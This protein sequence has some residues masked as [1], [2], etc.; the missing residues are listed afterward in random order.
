[1]AGMS[2]NRFMEFLKEHNISPWEYNEKDFERDQR[3]IT[4]YR[5]KVKK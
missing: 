3:A 5:K 2:R 4:A 1:M